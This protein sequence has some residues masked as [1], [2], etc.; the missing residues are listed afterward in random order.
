MSRASTSRSSSHRGGRATRHRSCPPATESVRRS[1]GSRDL[2][3]Y[4][5]SSPTRWHGSASFRNVP[6]D[7]RPTP[8][9]AAPSRCRLQQCLICGRK[10]SDPLGVLMIAGSNR[11]FGIAD[12]WL[13]HWVRIDEI[14][15]L[16]AVVEIGCARYESRRD[17]F[18]RAL[19]PAKLSKSGEQHNEK[20]L[21]PVVSLGVGVVH[22]EG[23]SILGA[24]A[25]C[26]RSGVHP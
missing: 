3:I 5:P 12:A 14:F 19:H 25:F 6:A 26:R 22:P 15:S 1:D 16:P 4:K 21:L 17:G 18:M 2:M 10:P 7:R 23:R 11:D 20:H 13:R 24:G 9:P 8:W